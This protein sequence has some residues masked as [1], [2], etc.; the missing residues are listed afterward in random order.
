MRPCLLSRQLGPGGE[1]WRQS[2]LPVVPQFEKLMPTGNMMRNGLAE[3]PRILGGLALVATN[4]HRRHIYS[5]AVRNQ[6]SGS[7]PGQ[8]V[9]WGIFHQH[10]QKRGCT[11]FS[12]YCAVMMCAIRERALQFPLRVSW[13]IL[14]GQEAKE[15]ARHCRKSHQALRSKRT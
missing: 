3:N 13:R 12:E 8:L 2:I 5:G 6:R 4:G 15:A 7:E 1:R 11:V 10:P 9:S 14:Y